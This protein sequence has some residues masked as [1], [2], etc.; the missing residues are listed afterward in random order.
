MRSNPSSGFAD[1]E[2]RIQVI[3]YQSDFQP[4]TYRVFSSE[5]DGR[6]YVKLNELT[7]VAI[8]ANQ[9]FR[10]KLP[11]GNPLIVEVTDAWGEII[12]KQL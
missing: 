9:E 1:T 10:T 2:F 11:N 12:T 4:I 7:S 3:G 8:S 5:A 6:N